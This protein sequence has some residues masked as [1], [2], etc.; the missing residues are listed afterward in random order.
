MSK[1]FDLLSV[2]EYIRVAHVLDA[3][4]V[5]GVDQN[6]VGVFGYQGFTD[7]LFEVEPRKRTE[8]NPDDGPV[9][10]SLTRMVVYTHY[11]GTIS[12]SGL[13]VQMQFG[14]D[15][16]AYVDIGP[17]LKVSAGSNKNSVHVIERPLPA[18]FLHDAT[19][20]TNINDTMVARMRVIPTSNSTGAVRV[21][22]MCLLIPGATTGR[23]SRPRGAIYSKAGI[24]Y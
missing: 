18:D 22:S 2:F 12:D 15:T 3:V 6:S 9:L 7:G 23:Q 14:R 5:S 21:H 17:N 11:Q 4:L 20:S 8:P 24:D 1:P 10:D 16:S 19:G 13:H